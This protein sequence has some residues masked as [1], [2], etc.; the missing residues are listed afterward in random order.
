MQNHQEPLL[1]R[2]PIVSG[3]PA[4]A[5]FTLGMAFERFETLTA[6]TLALLLLLLPVGLA[7]AN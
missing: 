4:D 2:K 3:D 5:P 7:C 1:N 6:T